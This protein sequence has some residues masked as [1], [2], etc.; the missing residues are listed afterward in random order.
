MK[1]WVRD[2]TRSRCPSEKKAY[3]Q[4]GLAVWTR[5]NDDTHDDSCETE[6]AKGQAASY[7]SLRYIQLCTHRWRGGWEQI[8]AG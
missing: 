6:V 8:N 1:E 4:A 2:M 3:S 7:S 5:K